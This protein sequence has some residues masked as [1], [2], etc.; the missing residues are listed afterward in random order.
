MFSYTKYI[1]FLFAVEF[2][3]FHTLVALTGTNIKDCALVDVDN[4]SKCSVC[5]MAN[6]RNIVRFLGNLF[7]KI[8]IKLPK[9]K[10][11]FYLSSHV[12]IN[13]VCQII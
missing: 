10:N 4:K 7:S 8:K 5:I 2:H 13:K 12:T 3:I 6:P 1:L 9:F 11:K